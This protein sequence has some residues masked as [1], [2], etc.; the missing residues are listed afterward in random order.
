[1]DGNSDG[2]G[3]LVSS[4]CYDV[5]CLPIIVRIES[6]TPSG[7]AIGRQ[8]IS[9]CPGSVAAVVI[10]IVPAPN[11]FEDSL[12]HGY[13]LNRSSGSSKVYLVCEEFLRAKFARVNSVSIY[14]SYVKYN[15]ENASPAMAKAN[16][17]AKKLSMVNT[18]THNAARQNR[19]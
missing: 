4:H 18:L 9:D 6:A 8:R 17:P 13:A 19:C 10:R 15:P 7:S 11:Y 12:M 2:L 5:S 16:N 14:A 1:M 3:D